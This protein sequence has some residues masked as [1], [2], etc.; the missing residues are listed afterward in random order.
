MM[1]HTYAIHILFTDGSNPYWR[2][3]MG[4]MEF[5]EERKRWRRNYILEFI[6]VDTVRDLHIYNY[7][8]TEIQKL[9]TDPAW[10]WD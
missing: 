8:A 9:Q 4:W 7:R 10:T 1:A 6:P 5:C 2:R 3:G